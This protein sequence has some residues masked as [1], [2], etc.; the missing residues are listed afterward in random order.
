MLTLLSR[1]DLAAAD[2]VAGTR[3]Q[4]HLAVHFRRPHPD[5]TGQLLPDAPGRY[6]IASLTKPIVSLLAVQL[7]AAGRLWLNEHLRTF[8]PDFRRGP[9]RTIT[10][11]HLLTHS[12]GLP[13]M[14]PENEQLRAAHASVAD[15]AAA[16]A[17]QDPAFQPGSAISY[18]SM[19]FALLQHVIELTAEQPLPQLLRETLLSPL[20]MHNS[21]LGLP[22]ENAPELLA[23]SLPCEL[24]PG[25]SPHTDWHWNSLYWR[26]LGAPWG[27]MTSTA[28]DLGRLLGCI[29]NNGRLPDGRQ[30][31]SP[32]VI[33]A[34][35]SN[36]TRCMASLPAADRETRPWGLGWRLNW[37]DH[38]GCFSDFLP[39]SAAGHWG[40]T[41][42]LM[43]VDPLSGRWCVI[44]TNQPFERSQRVIQQLSN[45]I[46]ATGN[47]S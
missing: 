6:L 40:A 29:A 8:R 42:T 32:A 34:S 39:E 21:W 47:S 26:T 17:T 35:L 13:D 43:W 46:A 1:S 30:L 5:S 11:R 23:H 12:S 9:L 10:L 24:P 37:P 25:Q 3:H 33:S 18:C 27:G 15:F 28:T 45:L 44:L 36:Q 14:L 19:G 2:V 4:T 41:G 16:T 22:A 38:H 31:I 7:A 20:G